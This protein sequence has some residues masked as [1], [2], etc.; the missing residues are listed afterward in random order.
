MAYFSFDNIVITGV[1]SAVPKQVVK[2]ES[3]YDTFGKENVDKFV[4][5]TGVKEV[6][7]TSAFQTASDLGYIAAEDLIAKKDVDRNDIGALVFVAHSTDYR[8]PATACV[9]HKRLQLSKDCVAFDVSLGCSAFVYGAQVIS[10]IMANSDIQKGLLIVGETMSKM[11]NENDK[12]SAMLFGDGGAAILFEKKQGKMSGMLCSDGEGYKAIIAPAGGFRN[13]NASKELIEFEEGNQKTLY[14]TWMDGSKVF[15]FTIRAVPKTIRE[16]M[17]KEGTEPDSYD[18]YIMHQANQYIH[19]Q[20]QKRLKM[21]ADKMPLCLDRYGN[22]SA[23]AIP[24]TLSDAFGNDAAERDINMIMSGFGV[25]LSWGVL[26]T[27]IS[28]ADIFPV[29]ETDDYF[30]EGIINSK[31]DWKG[32]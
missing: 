14:N 1:A 17:E 9:L 31:E 29:I 28:T 3:Y 19:K 21:T 5:M 8:R 18:Y 30:E 25:G 11:V 16:Y 6:R 4:K 2:A 15:E 23:A 13:M 12:S 32:E 27:S 26:G 24:L 10:S 20:L 7:K 22:T